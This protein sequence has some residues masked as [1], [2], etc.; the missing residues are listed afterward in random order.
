MSETFLL[1]G[2]SDAQTTPSGSFWYEDKAIL[3]D[4]AENMGF[5][6]LYHKLIISD[7]FVAH[8][9][10]GLKWR[11]AGTNNWEVSLSAQPFLHILIVSSSWQCSNLSISLPFL[12][13]A[14]H[15]MET[16]LT[17]NFWKS[18]PNSHHTPI[19]TSHVMVAPH[20][21]NYGTGRS[22]SCLIFFSI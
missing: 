17:Y 19:P 3:L 6:H 22:C 21:L 5:I 8:D 7:N 15:W 13:V 18:K 12:S 20:L 4:F 2:K 1:D 10:I 11:F 16:N 9:Q 14:Q